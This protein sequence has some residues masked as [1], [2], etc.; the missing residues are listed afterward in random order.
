MRA[1]IACCWAARS[2]SMPCDGEL[3]QVVEVR[4]LERRALAGR[5]DLDQAALAGHHDVRVDL[6]ARV[7]A[8]VEV[9]QRRAVD[10][11]ARDRGDARGQRALDAARLQRDRQR[12]VAAGD[13]RAAR[14]AVGGE[15]VAVDPHRAL[16]ELL[17]VDRLAQRAADEPLDLDR[18]P[19]GPALG[20]VALL[21][22]PGATR[23]ASRTR[24]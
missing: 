9:E 23:G 18:A 16:A 19:V 15:H 20:A 7:L 24:R 21:A 11:P 1:S 5:L 4:A 8:V 3:E 22:L 10:H 17:E 13:R 6:G 2:S 14:A 12:D